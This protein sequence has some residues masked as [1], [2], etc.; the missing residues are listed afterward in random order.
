MRC[1]PKGK[2]LDSW[3]RRR[4]PT[5]CSRP[6]AIKKR[7]PTIS[8]PSTGRPFPP[9]HYTL[10]KAHGRIEERTIRTTT[11]L[12]GFLNFPHVGQSF[13]IE[14]QVFF[15]KTGKQR[16]DLAY[17]ITDLDPASASPSR[18][19]EL[20][21]GHWSIENRLHWVRDVTFDEDRSQVRKGHGPQVLASIRN[22]IIGLLRRLITDERTSIASVVRYFTSRP[23]VALS[24]FTG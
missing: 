21:R 5:T 4:R 12:N 19:L 2:P 7:W 23:D 13:L 11:A 8:K 18:L 24:L 20:N 3:S 9:Q 14:R 10:D 15:P 6:R 16:T 22:F 17:G 1:T